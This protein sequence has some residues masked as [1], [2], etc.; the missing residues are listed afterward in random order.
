MLTMGVPE[1]EVSGHAFTHHQFLQQPEAPLGW[2]NNCFLSASSPG[3]IVSAPAG[4]RAVMLSTHVDVDGWLEMDVA[5][6]ARAKQELGDRLLRNA[7]LAYPDLGRRAQWLAVA[8]PRTYARFTRRHRG[9]VGG[10]RLTLHNSNQR[11]VPHDIGVSGW[12]QAG[13]TTWPGLGTT[14]CAICSQIAATDACRWA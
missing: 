11:A 1:E 4:Y 6:H 7:R 12:I 3:D 2:G 13:D 9:S 5:A 8:S 10:T 14:A